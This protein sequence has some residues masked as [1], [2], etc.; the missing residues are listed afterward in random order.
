MKIEGNYLVSEF[1]RDGEIIEHRYHFDDIE[2]IGDP[3]DGN[4][5]LVSNGAK[6]RDAHGWTFDIAIRKSGDSCILMPYSPSNEPNKEAD[7]RACW[8]AINEYKGE[9]K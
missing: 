3:Y 8:S 9:A 6:A 7:V 5:R 1:E 2:L 4:E